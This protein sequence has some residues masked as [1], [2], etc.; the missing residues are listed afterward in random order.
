[1]QKVA[2]QT[3]QWRAAGHGVRTFILTRDPDDPWTERVGDAVVRRYGGPMSRIRALIGLVEAV[4]AFEPDVVYLRWDLFYPPMLRFPRRA[5]LV[6]EINTDDVA[7]SAIGSGLRLRYN[8]LTRGILLRRA[9]A[10]VFVTSELSAKPSF[11]RFKATHRVVTN[12]IDLA[13]YPSLPAVEGPVP[14]L[15][16]VGTAGQ[17]WHGLDK[18]VALAYRRPDWRFDIVGMTTDAWATQAPP[19]NVSWHGALDRA[20]VVEVL[21]TADVGVGT[22]A[23]HRKSMTEACPLKVREYLAVGL[24]ILYGYTDP[25]ADDLGRYAL[26]IEN[27]ETNVIDALDAIDAF[28]TQSRGVRVP[29]SAVGHLDVAVK[30]GQR[31]A[32]FDELVHA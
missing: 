1:L 20:Q 27:T 21:A 8:A 24:P 22:L 32:L 31:L 29:R 14:R 13:A 25:D 28:V 9:R 2:G 18:L 26:R 12:G 23:L 16:F 19:A 3:D 30:E 10:L 11:A 6:I 15:A 5:P 17:P 4:R 7:E